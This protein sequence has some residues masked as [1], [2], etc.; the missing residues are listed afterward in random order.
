[1]I[2][3]NR[4]KF[5]GGDVRDFS[6]AI[7]LF[8]NYCKEK[9]LD[10][11]NGV[12]EN[13]QKNISYGL[14]YEKNSRF[15]P[16]VP[17]H[18]FY[19][20]WEYDFSKK[21]NVN[22]VVLEHYDAFFFSEIE[23]YTFS[24]IQFILTHC[25]EKKIYSSDVMADFFWKGKQ[26]SFVESEEELS[27]VENLL[28]VYTEKG[29]GSRGYSSLDMM[30]WLLWDEFLQVVRD[31]DRHPMDRIVWKKVPP[32]FIMNQDII[33]LSSLENQAMRDLYNAWCRCIPM[34]PLNSGN[35]ERLFSDEKALLL[36]TE[37]IYPPCKKMTVEELNREIVDSDVRKLRKAK[38]E[39]IWMED[40]GVLRSE[41]RRWNQ[42]S[43]LFDRGYRLIPVL[44]EKKRVQG[45]L[46]DT[47]F[48]MKFPST[49]YGINSRISVEFSADKN[50]LKDDIAKC[51]SNYKCNEVP[52]LKKGKLKG[53]AAKISCLGHIPLCKVDDIQPVHWNYISDEVAKEFFGTCKK[54]IIS[55]SC[56]PLKGFKERFSSFLEITALSPDNLD[57]YFAGEF[58]MF[59]Y[60]ADLYPVGVIPK[61]QA[62]Q[63]YADLLVE[64]V[65]RY[66]QGQGVWYRC[67][68]LSGS[69]FN[70]DYRVSADSFIPP[71]LPPTKLTGCR[72]E[73]Y[74]HADGFVEDKT[75]F[76]SGRR[77]TRESRQKNIRNSIYLFGPCTAVGASVQD[78]GETIESF[79][80]ELLDDADIPYRVVNCGAVAAGLRLLSD[81]NGIYYMMDTTFSS[82]DIVVHFGMDLW[83]NNTSFLLENYSSVS[84]MMN[85]PSNRM[86]R[87]LL[88]NGPSAHHID[89]HGYRLVARYLF[90]ELSKDIPTVQERGG[91][92]AFPVPSFS[93]SVSVDADNV[94]NRDP[95]LSE[96]VKERVDVPCAGAIV[97]NCNPFT[98]GHLYLIECALKMVD[99]LYVF[100]V[101]EDAS[102]ISF[103]DRFAMVRLNCEKFQRVKV[104]PSGKYMISSITFEEYFQKDAIQ[105]KAVY[106]AKDVRIFGEKI[107]PLLHISKRF[108][109]EEPL[110]HVTYQ[111]NM[112]MKELLPQYG[113]ELVEIPRMET[114]GGHVIN[115]TEV[116]RCIRENCLERCREYLTEVSYDYIEEHLLS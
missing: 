113:V 43:A 61:Y 90:E 27:S 60:G 108:V 102:E 84:S 91:R 85:R 97:M 112:T 24:V 110:D 23:E 105:E 92:N 93:A 94:K 30:Q 36:C 89:K 78:D 107:A 83:H 5:S 76:I 34:I 29:K 46:S 98:K 10:Y 116:R 33:Y 8:R 63:L 16:E 54:V 26:V 32:R 75:C 114:R 25:P 64:E 35:Y 88:Y 101:E 87:F 19:N 115:A 72:N 79:L 111:Y 82:G 6:L 18:D 13:R 15:N 9:S 70:L 104:L 39:I 22:T 37:D 73:Y 68:D 95:Y 2:R 53:W 62:R 20:F 47:Q 106:P 71:S 45:V 80:Q 1:M 58:D 55:S 14:K 7:A 52:I 100:V 11:F 4:E 74:T 48:R 42:L 67:F 81:I 56:G 96:L 103:K 12:V 3:I 65:R 51:L 57:L 17:K 50:K 21:E 86:M 28:E 66:L 109:G 99:F 41:L 49:N 59:L 40:L 77:R 38:I 44:D 69:I 31:T